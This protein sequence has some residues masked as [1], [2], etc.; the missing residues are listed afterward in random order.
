M[1][2]RPPPRG[3]TF[4]EFSGG[5]QIAPELAGLRVNVYVSAMAHAKLMRAFQRLCLWPRMPKN[6]SS[7][8]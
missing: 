2:L 4:G 7:S 5:W 6:Q 3:P 8:A 1:R